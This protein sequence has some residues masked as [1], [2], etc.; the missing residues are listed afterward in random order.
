M[1]GESAAHRLAFE[2][3]SLYLFHTMFCLMWMGL[4]QW[5]SAQ[6]EIWNGLHGM[7]SC[8]LNAP[9][10]EKKKFFT[11]YQNYTLAFISSVV[12]ECLELSLS[13]FLWMVQKG[14]FKYRSSSSAYSNNTLLYSNYQSCIFQFTMPQAWIIILWIWSFWHASMSV[15]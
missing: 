13:E 11:I 5:A 6:F 8:L 4:V 3:W 7:F 2:C 10:E 1:I 12:R 14:Y 15:T 9:K